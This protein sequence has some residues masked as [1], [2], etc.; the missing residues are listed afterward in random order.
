ME[1]LTQYCAPGTRIFE[2]KIALDSETKLRVI[3]FRPAGKKRAIAVVFVAGWMSLID[4]WRKVLR[5][6]TRDFTVYYIETREKMSSRVKGKAGFGIRDIG[7]DI[8]RMVDRLGLKDQQ[9]VI[10]ASSLGA[11]AVFDCCSFFTVSPQALIMINPNAVFRIPFFWKIL[12]R[13]FYAPLFVI[14]RPMIKWYLRTFRLDVQA[15]P[16]QYQKYCRTLDNA[17]PRKSKKTAMALWNY[18]VWDKLEAVRF[19]TLVV[20]ASRDKLHEPENIRRMVSMLPGATYLDM[21]TNARNHSPELVEAIRR[22]LDGLNEN[23]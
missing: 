9:Y 5:E 10:V 20:G 2:E 6:M 17:D 18:Q 1:D 11:T 16:T 15:D 19:P 23:P 12:V 21:E 8:V 14:F 3:A 4:G 13:L 7:M 22:Y